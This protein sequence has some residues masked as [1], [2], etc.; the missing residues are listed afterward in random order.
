MVKLEGGG[1]G[2]DGCAE[3]AILFTEHKTALSAFPQGRAFAFSP[4]ILPLN[5]HE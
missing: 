4:S 2:N 1:T 3:G 5:H